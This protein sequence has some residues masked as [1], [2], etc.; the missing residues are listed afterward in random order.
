MQ[1]GTWFLLLFSSYLPSQ[2]RIFRFGWRH[3]RG[4]V[5]SCHYLPMF[6][7]TLPTLASWH[8]SLRNIAGVLKAQMFSKNNSTWLFLHNIWRASAH[9]LAR[10][11]VM[12]QLHK[13]NGDKERCSWNIVQSSVAWVY[14]NG[15]NIA[16][17]GCVQP[18]LIVTSSGRGW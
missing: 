10:L 6:S 2:V 11:P 12:T 3:L 8:H 15:H 13:E 9:Q 17:T 4:P 14:H 16:T 7:L 1:T 18:P 5:R